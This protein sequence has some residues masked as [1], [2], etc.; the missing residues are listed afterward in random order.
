[1]KKIIVILLA[2]F[3][4]L[5]VYAQDFESGDLKKKFY[6][7]GGISTPT[8]TYYGAKNMNMLKDEIGAESKIGA[9]FEIGSIFMLNGIDLGPGLRF[10]INV[11]YLSFKAQVFRLQGGD[12]LYNFFIGSKIGPSFT[13][14]PARALAFDIY[15]KINPVWVGAIYANL[16]N[17]SDDD[18]KYYLGYVQLMYSFGINVRVSVL[19][20]GF[21]Y[22]IG[23]LALKNNKSGEYWPDLS[24]PNSKKT[25]M[26][27]FNVTIGL[28]F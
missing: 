18:L 14:Q 20:I 6:L 15:A 11:D 24:D 26:P 1:M 4:S 22:D 21:E 28:N 16:Q 8:W 9:N 3:I 10:G 13:Y 5:S 2:V 25:P 12:N 7:R 27:G 19:M 23:S 17:L